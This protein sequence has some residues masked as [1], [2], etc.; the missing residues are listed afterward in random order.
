MWSTLLCYMENGI[1]C[2]SNRITPVM[3]IEKLC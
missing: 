2:V 3:L 1:E